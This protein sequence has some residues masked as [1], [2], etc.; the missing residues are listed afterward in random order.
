M[1]YRLVP[2]LDVP[3]ADERWSAVTQ[4]VWPEYNVHGDVAAETADLA[5]RGYTIPFAWNG[6]AAA[7]PSFDG[8]I[9][10]GL[11]LRECGGE[12]N[13]LSAL[14][15]A[16]R[17]EHQGQG[18]A[19]RMISHMQALAREHGLGG[20]VAPLRPTWKERYPLAPIE[21][22]AFWTRTDGAPFDPWIRL[23]VRL[24]GEILRPEPRSLRITGTVA[25]WEAWVDLPLPESGLYVFPHGLAPLEVVREED[26]GR[27]WEPNVW[28]RHEAG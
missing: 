19:E 2:I 24:G 14:A 16:I 20:L 13:T 7:L 9:E 6:D 10:A 1:A 8:V 26:V 21:R 23:H 25:E 5:G 11:A 3:D 4:G 28:V 15:I 18:L 17:P 22:Y 12:A 27:Y